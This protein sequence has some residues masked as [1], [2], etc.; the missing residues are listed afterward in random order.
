MTMTLTTPTLDHLRI[1][2]GIR[3][4]GCEAIV[5]TAAEDAVIGSRALEALKLALQQF[6]L[7]VLEVKSE[8][9]IRR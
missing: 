5:D 9:Q 8:K 4:K 6:Q 3:V 2:A 1:Y 7:Q